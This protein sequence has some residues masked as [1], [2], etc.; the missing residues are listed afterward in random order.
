MSS[1]EFDVIVIGSGPGG[2]VGAIR[3]AQLGLKTA[4]VEKD[5]TFGGTCLNVG[6]IPSKALLES[7]EHF[8]AAQ[9]E[10][11]KHGVETSGVKLNLDT[12]M[13]R[14]NKI[15]SEL[16]G[17]I[18]FLFEKNK[19]TSFEGTGKILSPNEVLVS[20]NDGSTET[21]KTKNIVLATGSVP[22]S[23]RHQL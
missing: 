13:T 19:I 7:S 8:S 3:M 15:V 16:T 1:E 14:K 23:L 9:H 20:K 22:N 11:E 4:V 17:G 5:P 10:L 18:K 21:L 2:Y 12:M 6:C